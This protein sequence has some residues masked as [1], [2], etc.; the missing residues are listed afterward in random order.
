MR[1][2]CILFIIGVLI[3]LAGVGVMIWLIASSESYTAGDI[4]EAF[5]KTIGP[6]KNTKFVGPSN[7]FI[8]YDRVSCGLSNVRLGFEV[9]VVFAAVTN[10]TLVIPPKS[11]S[12]HLNGDEYDELDIYDENCLR[13]YIAITR[14]KPLCNVHTIKELPEDHKYTSDYLT[15][16]DEYECIHFERIF[17]N[18]EC[19]M[20]DQRRREIVNKGLR[21]REEHIQAA[22]AVL[23]K[24]NLSVVGTYNALHRR[25]GDIVRVVDIYPSESFVKNVN[26]RLE[27]EIPLLYVSDERDENEIEELKSKGF[28]VIEIEQKESDSN[29]AKMMVDFIACCASKVFLGTQLSTFSTG[30][31]TYRGRVAEKYK[32]IDALPEY[33]NKSTGEIKECEC[34]NPTCF[35]YVSP[36][37]WQGIEQTYKWD[38]RVVDEA[39]FINRGIDTSRKD[40]TEEVIRDIGLKPNRIEPVTNTDKDYSLT[41]THKKILET[42]AMYEDKKFHCIFE[43]DIE[44]IIPRENMLN[45]IEK[46]LHDVEGEFVYLGVCL[47]NNQAETCKSD[48]C[49]AWC[50]HAYMVTPKGAQNLLETVSFNTGSTIDAQFLTTFSA[51]V[52]GLEYRSLKTTDNHRGLFYQDRTSP[53]YNKIFDRT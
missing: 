19:C 15:S 18:Y 14:D 16:L 10:R 11:G 39:F 46:R 35:G 23:L 33:F 37:M 13:K 34:S 42:I 3:L 25:R 31:M 12:N 29:L 6:C 2:A 40:H 20:D 43:D 38:R 26:E 30:I 45:E 4:Y 21:F 8:S 5:M 44:C 48:E 22:S 53:W 36:D 51:P 27:K 28:R 32:A 1:V 24:H 9:L 41:L 17:C 49:N 7:R 47:D 52:L 50:A